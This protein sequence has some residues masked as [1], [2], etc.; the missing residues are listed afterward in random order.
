MRRSLASLT[1]L[2]LSTPVALSQ[3]TVT[4]SPGVELSIPVRDF[5]DEAG[6]GF[7]GV[8]ESRAGCGKVEPPG[9]RGADL[10]LHEA[11]GGREEHVGC[12]RGHDDD[13]DL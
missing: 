13:V 3:S 1:I 7:K 9:S 8:Q 11:G 12:H 2:V 10:P 6:T 5:A 4:L